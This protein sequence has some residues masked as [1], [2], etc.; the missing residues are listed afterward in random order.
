MYVLLNLLAGANP[1]VM[2]DQMG[3]T[4]RP[5]AGQAGRTQ[6]RRV[7]T[8][9]ETSRRAPTWLLRV[10]PATKLLRSIE[11][12]IDPAQLAKSTPPG[13]TLAIDQFGWASGARSPSQVPADRSFAFVAPTP[14]FRRRSMAQLEQPGG[15]RQAH[16]GPP[17]RRSWASPPPTSPMTLLDGR[18]A[19]PSYYARLP[20]SPARSS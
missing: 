20:N 5:A 4:L 16:L 9:I 7:N 1:D 12:K 13:Q 10:D 14:K 17:Y 19:R 2:L 6:A 3:G 15:A 8:L 18:R 11:L